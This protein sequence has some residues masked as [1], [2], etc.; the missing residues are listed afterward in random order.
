MSEVYTRVKTGGG[1]ARRFPAV[2]TLA[3]LVALCICG[4]AGCKDKH[5]ERGIERPVVT[6]VTVSSVETTMTREIYEATG[7]VHSESTSIIS[8]RVMAMVTSLDVKEGDAVKKGQL[9]LTIDDRDAAERVKAASLA[10]E[11]ARQNLRPG[12]DDLEALP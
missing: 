3:V 8:S 11:A 6:G 9:L 5:G 2:P 10:L 7:T 1:K 12:R 4:V